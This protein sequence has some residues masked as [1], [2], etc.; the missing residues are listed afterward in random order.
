MT[1]YT[2]FKTCYFGDKYYGSQRQPELHTI[3]GELLRALHNKAYINDNQLKMQEIH[4]AGRTDAGVHARGMTYG[5]FNQ[6]ESFHPIEV[7]TVLPEDILIWSSVTIDQIDDVMQYHPRF[8]ARKRE[9][10]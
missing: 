9:Y 8:Q 1:K 2:L 6:R 4:S 5:F 7:N 10:I 3:E